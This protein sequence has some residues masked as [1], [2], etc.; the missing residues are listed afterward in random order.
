MMQS[1]VTKISEGQGSFVWRRTELGEGR[2]KY[3]NR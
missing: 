1:D 3:R 2:F